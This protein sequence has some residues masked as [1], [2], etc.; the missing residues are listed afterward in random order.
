M[1]KKFELPVT[2]YSNNKKI[3]SNLKYKNDFYNGVEEYFLNNKKCENIEKT[4]SNLGYKKISLF[5]K[6]VDGKFVE[7]N[8]FKLFEYNLFSKE[9]I[10]KIKKWHDKYMEIFNKK[11]CIFKLSAGLDSRVLLSFL[12]NSKKTFYIDNY[13]RDTVYNKVDDSYDLYFIQNIICKKYKNIKMSNRL[14]KKI[15]HLKVGGHFSEWCR[16]ASVFKNKTFLE[17]AYLC[18]KNN[19]IYPMIDKELLT[20]NPVI[21]DAL[22]TIIIYMYA[23]ELLEYN[24]L[25]GNSLYDKKSLPLKY[26]KMVE[27]WIN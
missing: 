7:D 6:I 27:K 4:I 15:K 20:I 21:K 12:I 24:F 16:D 22:N 14:I 9:G 3:I 5:E 13:H 25:S 11:F 19:F 2:Y 18:R 10:E 17:Y 1:K 23:P 26:I 8:N